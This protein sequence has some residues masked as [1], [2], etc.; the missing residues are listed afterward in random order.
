VKDFFQKQKIEKSDKI[1]TADKYQTIEKRLLKNAEN[2]DIDFK[3]IVCF[4][5]FLKRRQNTFC[6]YPSHIGADNSAQSFE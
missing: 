3:K 2:F 5:L 6:N 4:G 1:C